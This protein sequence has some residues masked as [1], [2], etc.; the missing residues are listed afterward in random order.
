MHP[1]GP[2]VWGGY[3]PPCPEDPPAARLQEWS[4]PTPTP[5]ASTHLQA[6]GVAAQ[7]LVLQ[8]QGCLQRTPAPAGMSTAHEANPCQSYLVKLRLNSRLSETEGWSLCLVLLSCDMLE[9]NVL[10]RSCEGT[11]YFCCGCQSQ[12]LLFPG[13]PPYQAECVTPLPHCLIAS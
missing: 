4:L 5:R 2:L 7:S 3:W 10:C 9:G 13:A 12:P 11:R 6:L 1:F 8:L